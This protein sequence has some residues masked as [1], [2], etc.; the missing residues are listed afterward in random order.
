MNKQKY[1][2]SELKN[3]TEYLIDSFSQCKSYKLISP[4]R[5]KEEIAQCEHCK[6]DKWY[7]YNNKIICSN[8]FTGYYVEDGCN[9]ESI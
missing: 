2:D 3:F 1:I 9:L 4:K 5:H 6:N 7:R 8:C